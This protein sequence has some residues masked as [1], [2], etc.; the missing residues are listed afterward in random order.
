MGRVPICLASCLTLQ[1]A[2]K[3]V[4]VKK[5]ALWE[6]L[7]VRHWLLSGSGRWAVCWMSTLHFPLSCT[8]LARLVWTAGTGVVV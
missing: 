5:M 3:K 2:V 1:L 8:L 6:G 4:K 7:H